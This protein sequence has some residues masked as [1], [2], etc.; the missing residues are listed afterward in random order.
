MCTLELLYLLTV[1]FANFTFHGHCKFV[2]PTSTLEFLYLCMVDF[3]NFNDT[4][5]L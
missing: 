2:T 5:S 4:V 1:D 3:A